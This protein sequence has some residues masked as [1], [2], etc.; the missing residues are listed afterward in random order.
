MLLSLV[1]SLVLYVI[2][3]I[4]N[5]VRTA[6]RAVRGG[7]EWMGVVVYSKLVYS[8]SNSNSSNS[9]SNTNANN[10]WQLVVV[11][12]VFVL[13]KLLCIVMCAP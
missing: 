11:L 2:S 10:V 8:S 3:T 12:V 1:V 5:S 4:H 13:V 7:V 6:P 9:N